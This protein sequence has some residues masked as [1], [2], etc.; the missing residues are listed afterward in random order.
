[1]HFSNEEFYHIYNR[2]FNKQKI[3]FKEENYVYFIRKLSSLKPLCEIVAY[4]LM[5]D[6]FHLMAFI[7]KESEA[8]R[9]TAQ[10]GLTGIQLI[11]RKLGTILSSYTQA[12]NKQEDRTGSLFQPKTK[13]KELD[14]EEYLFNCFHYIHQ[15]PHKS[16]LVNRIKDY[17][18]S[19]FNDYYLDRSGICS[20]DVAY[21]FMD[22]LKDKTQF[23]NQSYQLIE[24]AHDIE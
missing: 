24:Y 3:F 20:K 7:P 12:I 4:C 19:S 23:L 22:V 15:N 5:P 8:T 21:Q 10:S 13:A 9:L 16:G 17:P 6:H 14:K 1:M 11:S 2:S 18:F